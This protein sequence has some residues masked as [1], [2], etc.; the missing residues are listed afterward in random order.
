M[1]ACI[2]GGIAEA[3]YKEIPEEILRQIWFRLPDDFRQIVQARTDPTLPHIC[4][5]PYYL[6]GIKN[7]KDMTAKTIIIPIGFNAEQC[8][9][10]VM[11][12]FTSKD[13]VE[14]MDD[15]DFIVGYLYCQEDGDNNPPLEVWLLVWDSPGNMI[16]HPERACSSLYVK[17]PAVS[18]NLTWCKAHHKGLAVHVIKVLPPTSGQKF[19][20]VEDSWFGNVVDHFHTVDYQEEMAHADMNMTFVEFLSQMDKKIAGLIQGEQ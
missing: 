15:H 1:L 7:S 18:V 8:Q 3:Y 4:T 6:C 14:W 11:S 2:T 12:C 10:G 5:P 13:N 16:K 20:I 9:E 17:C 19:P